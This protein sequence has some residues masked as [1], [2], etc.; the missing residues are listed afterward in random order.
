MLNL[1]HKQHIFYT[2]FKCLVLRGVIM[3][4]L[5]S[6]NIYASVNRMATVTDAST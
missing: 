2:G 1:S 5:V 6:L 3:S 4:C